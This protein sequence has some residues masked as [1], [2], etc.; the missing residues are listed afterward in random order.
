MA[1]LVV[2]A[3]RLFCYNTSI[4]SY[5]GL[6]EGPFAK[7]V[8]LIGVIAIWLNY[9]AIFIVLLKAFFDFKLINNLAK[10]ICF[11][12][13]LVSLIL[14]YPIITLLLGKFEISILLIT[15][16]IETI[17]GL[18]LSAYNFITI[19]EQNS[20]KDILFMFLAFLAMMIAS[21][22]GYFMQFVFGFVKLAINSKELS[23]FHRGLLYGAI[24]VPVVLYFFLRNKDQ[25]VIRFTLIYISVATMVGFIV[26]NDYSYLNFSK[27]WTWPFH[28]CNTA[29]FIVPLCLIFKL[30]RL[31]YFTYFINVFG[32]LL[33]MLTP[34]YDPTTNI[35]SN[36]LFTFWYNHYIAFFMPLLCVALHEFERP[37]LKQFIYSMIGFLGYFVLALFLNVYFTALASSNPSLGIGEVDY[38]FLNTNWLC[39]KLGDWAIRLF[40]ISASINVNG[41]TLVFHPA[42]QI[43]FFATYVGLGLA[44]WFVYAEGF[45]IAD[46]HGALHNKLKEINDY[47][48]FINT[49]QLT[50]ERRDM[51][52]KENRRASL[53][54]KNFTKVYASSKKYAVK[55]ASLKINEGEIF[56][57]LG[58]NGAGKSTIIKSIVGIQPKT[59]GEILICDYDNAK[60]PV[61]SKALL[62]YVPDHY[63]L[64]EKLTGR[65]YINYIADIYEVSKEERDERIT[66]Y[67]KLFELDTQIDNKIKTYS[68]GMKQK[69]T[70]I[71]ALVHNP[72]VWILDEPLTGLDPNSIYQV[73][74]CMKEHA[75]HGNIV[76]FSSHLIDIVE[77][78]CGRIA[79]I[80]HGH[81][82]CVRE[83]KDIEKESS[84]EEYYLSIIGDNNENS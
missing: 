66:R 63:A 52:I 9:T 78:L 47:H 7:G 82:E 44:I 41:L 10:Y 35:F 72:K 37:K 70:I 48:D 73:K 24:I 81:I 4:T 46:V 74:E 2:F 16:I 59:S 58:P 56:G 28:L 53:E 19:K 26:N 1:L 64:Y 83:V 54:L 11:P 55:D 17:I 45:R 77:K 62:G 29:M 67:V 79:I 60:Y 23:S 12:I 22:P 65:E 80:K 31:F 8:N 6:G 49:N 84:L 75:S 32:A 61:E 5:I 13:F 57:F 38:F 15:F 42:Y 14:I 40:N 30:K 69:I 33:A 3:I 20:K 36:R 34:N 76:F 43:S 27:P 25:K 71:S 68:H 51:M 50:K 39:D 18:V 21:L